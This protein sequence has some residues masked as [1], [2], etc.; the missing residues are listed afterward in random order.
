MLSRP[1]LQQEGLWSRRMEEL[2]PALH[3]HREPAGAGT[4]VRQPGSHPEHT[5]SYLHTYLGETRRSYQVLFAFLDITCSARV[6]ARAPQ[7]T[8]AKPALSGL[9]NSTSLELELLSAFPCSS[10]QRKMAFSTQPSAQTMFSLPKCPQAGPWPAEPRM[11][12]S[13]LGTSAGL[14]YSFPC[15]TLQLDTTEILNTDA[16]YQLFCYM[17]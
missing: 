4:A 10:L 16:I 15:S 5:G 1:Y 7:N 11:F 9:R 17:K 14:P 12:G 3:Q 2:P 8:A 13:V 6:L